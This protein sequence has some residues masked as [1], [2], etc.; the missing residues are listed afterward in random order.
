MVRAA[1]P[2]EEGQVW[3]GM[4]DETYGLSVILGVITGVNLLLEILWPADD[5]YII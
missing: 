3:Q 1:R 4:V 5:M 2:Y